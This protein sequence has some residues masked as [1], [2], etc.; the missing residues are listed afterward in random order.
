MYY[1]TAGMESGVEARGYASLQSKV[2]GE[3]S[4]AGRHLPSINSA[5]GS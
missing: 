1:E 5:G 4:P 3:Q 2:T